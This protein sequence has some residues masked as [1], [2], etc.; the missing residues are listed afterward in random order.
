MFLCCGLKVQAA[1]NEMRGAGARGTE[2]GGN[3]KTKKIHEIFKQ[4]DSLSK[5]N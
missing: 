5:D 1:A 4:R 2:V 3:G